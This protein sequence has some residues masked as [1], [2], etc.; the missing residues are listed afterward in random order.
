MAAAIILGATFND[1]PYQSRRYETNHSDHHLIHFIKTVVSEYS[2]SDGN[3][4]LKR[5]I[6]YLVE[7]D[8]FGKRGEFEDIQGISKLDMSLNNEVDELRLR[9]A[10]AYTIEIG[11]NIPL[12]EF[13]ERYNIN[14]NVLIDYLDR[15]K[16]RIDSIIN[17]LIVDKTVNIARI[18]EDD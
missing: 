9:I 1:L 6:R 7:N 5:G 4:Y 3:S 8:Y 18:S 13:S 16:A 14:K 12:R 15:Q 17:D 10:L 11:D 2:G